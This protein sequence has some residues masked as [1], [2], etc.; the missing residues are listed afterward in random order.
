MAKLSK[1]EYTKQAEERKNELNNRVLECAKNFS[2]SP[3]S[4][5]EYLKF[6]SN[7]Y[8]YSAKNTILIQ[9]Q[10]PAAR[11]CGSFKSFKD[12]GYSVKKEE[13]SMKIFVPTH[14]TFLETEDGDTIALS[15]ATKQQ[16]ADYKAG[17]IKS[18]QKLYFKV[19]S[20]FDISQTNCPKSDY[21]KLLDLGYSSKHHSDL[22]DTLKNYSVEKLNCPVLEGAYSSVTLRGLYSITD[23]E[24]KISNSFDDTTKLSILSHELGHAILHSQYTELGDIKLSP[25]Q[26]EFEAD[27]VSVM[28]YNRFGLEISESRQR[29][30]SESFKDFTNSKGYKPEMLTDSL[31]RANSAYRNVNEYLN[32]HLP[33]TQEVTIDKTQSLPTQQ[34]ILPN[35]ITSVGFVQS[36]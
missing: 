29:H 1:S 33:Q 12:K 4:M 10:N 7:F 25:A 30:L 13:S 14:K 20:V 32:E 15:E 9:M 22:F 31:E 36:M 34:P 26:T 35:E 2:E 8:Q 11:F 18:F 19:G 27:A 21:P 23:N 16:K 17:K 24:I 5:M 6:Q 3:E 28:L